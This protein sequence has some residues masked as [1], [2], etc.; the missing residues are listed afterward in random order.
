MFTEIRKL[1]A[2]DNEMIVWIQFKIKKVYLSK[3]ECEV[4]LQ[5]LHVT[6]D[7][8]EKVG[9]TTWRNS[10]ARLKSDEWRLAY[11]LGSSINDVT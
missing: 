1:H 8:L 9:K 10:E 2:I 11:D 5:A 4:G 6:V 7:G 3:V